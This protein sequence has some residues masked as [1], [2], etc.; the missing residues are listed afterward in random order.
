MDIAR[1][2]LSTCTTRE[3][4][5]VI[6][7][8]PF[9]TNKLIIAEPNLLLLYFTFVENPPVENSCRPSPQTGSVRKQRT[10]LGR[11]QIQLSGRV[12]ADAGAAR[13]VIPNSDTMQP[14]QFVHKC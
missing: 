7:H 10:K 9:I 6:R 4:L 14:A 11:E 1:S 2:Y 5:Q 8:T 12:S 3:W 13:F